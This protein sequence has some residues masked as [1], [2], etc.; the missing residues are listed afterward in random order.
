MTIIKPNLPPNAEFP[1]NASWTSGPWTLPESLLHLG[2]AEQQKM[3][4]I[5]TLSAPPH[6]TPVIATLRTQWCRPVIQTKS[7]LALK[8]SKR[9]ITRPYGLRVRPQTNWMRI[10]TPPLTLHSLTMG[11][12]RRYHGYSL[13]QFSH[14]KN[15]GNG[16]NDLIG[17]L[18][19]WHEFLYIQCS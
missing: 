2:S 7:H 14:L 1:S 16:N 5:W 8:Y 17:L 11:P 13:P 12:W 19:T 3:L 6:S 9:E 15:G 10:P 4:S 18:W